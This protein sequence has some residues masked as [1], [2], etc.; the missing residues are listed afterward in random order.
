MIYEVTEPPEEFKP[1]YW[2]RRECFSLWQNLSSPVLQRAKNLGV[3]P[4]F[5]IPSCPCGNYTQN[6]V[7]STHKN[8]SQAT[9]ILTNLADLNNC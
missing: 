3:I 1:N 9:R 2:F 7:F 8:L 6:M 4:N 5:L